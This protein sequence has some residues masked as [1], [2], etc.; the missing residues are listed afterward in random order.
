M[1]AETRYQ[2]IGREQ[3]ERQA[4]RLRAK[5]PKRLRRARETA[6]ERHARLVYEQD[7]DFPWPGDDIP[8]EPLF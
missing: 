4:A 3:A 7:R 8:D 2:R 6:L 5:L 1:K